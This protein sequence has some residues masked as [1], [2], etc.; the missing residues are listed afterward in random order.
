MKHVG[1]CLIGNNSL[2][3]GGKG[4]HLVKDYP[5]VRL[6][7]R[8]ISKLNQTVLI[9]KIQKGTFSMHSRLGVSKTA[10]PMS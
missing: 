9:Q 6:K 8:E 10:L 3:G 4:V 5:N 7:V 2:N 1:E